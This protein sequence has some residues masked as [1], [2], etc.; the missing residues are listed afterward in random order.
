M[1]II[2]FKIINLM[3]QIKDTSTFEKRESFETK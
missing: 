1:N 2:F 3:N